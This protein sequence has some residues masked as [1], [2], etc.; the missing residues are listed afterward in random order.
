MV[1]SA[2]NMPTLIPGYQCVSRLGAGGFGEVWRV[3][4]PGG[5]EKAIKLVY[6]LIDEDRAAREL[7]SLDRIKGVRHPFLL[8][9]ERIEIIDGRLMIVT[10][11]AEGSLV[12]RYKECQADG[13][14]GIPREELIGHL[15]DAADALDFMFQRHSLQHLDIK[16]EN[17]LLVGGHTKVADFGLVKEV[18]ERTVS[19][20]GGLTPIYASP[21]TFSGTPSRQSDQYSLAVVYQELLTGKLPFVGNTPAQ[22]AMMH[23]QGCPHLS[24][25]PAA[26]RAIVGRALA[27]DPQ[28]RY[29]SSSDFVNALRGLPAEDSPPASPRTD[30]LAVSGS[31]RN[32][33]DTDETVPETKSAPVP[34]DKYRDDRPNTE[35]LRTEV[36][37]NAEGKGDS[38]PFQRPEDAPRPVI[39]VSQSVRRLKP[40]GPGELPRGLRPTLFVGVGGLGIETVGLLKSRLERWNAAYAAE[41]IRYLV[42]DTDRLAVEAAGRRESDA[43]IASEDRLCLPLRKTNDYKNGPMDCLQWLSRRWLYNIPR[44]LR[45]QGFR[46]LGRLALV[47]HWKRVVEAIDRRIDELQGTRAAELVSE[48]S[49]Q[50]AGE[51]T[52]RV[53]VVGS[54]SGGTGGGML[55]DVGAVTRRLLRRAGIQ[56]PEVH[57]M[58]LHLANRQPTQS[59]L[60]AAS[61]YAT[62]CELYHLTRSDD[63]TPA[64][65]GPADAASR[66]GPPFDATEFV[67]LGEESSKEE[68]NAQ[69]GRLA[70]YLVCQSTS[71]LGDANAISDPEADGALNELDVELRSFA[72]Q[73][74]ETANSNLAQRVAEAVLVE[75]AQ[76]WVAHGSEPL[77]DPRPRARAAHANLKPTGHQKLDSNGGPA[78][79]HDKTNHSDWIHERAA[80]K[81]GKLAS[82]RFAKTV[83]RLLCERADEIAQNDRKERGEFDQRAMVMLAAAVKQLEEI[84]LVAES[85][86]PTHSETDAPL[87][88]WTSKLRELVPRLA[89]QVAAAAWEEFLRRYDPHQPQADAG[90]RDAPPDSLIENARGIALHEAITALRELA[91]DGSI[92]ATGR[93]VPSADSLQC[94]LEA[95]APV[96]PGGHCCRD[97]IILPRSCDQSEASA[98]LREALAETAEVFSGSIEDCPF[99][100]RS[101][102]GVSLAET[103]KLLIGDRRDLMEAARRLHARKDVQWTYPPDVKSKEGD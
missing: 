4:A 10:E 32:V 11:L 30:G 81:F 70:D 76:R 88:E 3:S 22:L 42:L 2:A 90:S 62:L 47:D 35:I 16:P 14:P 56:Q 48:V 103:A 95:L 33:E 65:D 97:S 69:L 40:R 38:G 39:Q 19:L 37:D 60:A 100:V 21:E 77:P 15:H 6:G 41:A 73:R 102:A 79:S 28:A 45:T 34:D 96:V 78:A 93:L 80:Y 64:D 27:K 1:L 61:A 59:A 58:L 20:V 18:V 75:V 52:P 49:G 67:N 85:G 25:L 94:E 29:G 9:L 89:G 13:L 63:E 8:S 44:S 101:A 43:A 54:V 72:V 55:L 99:I 71:P 31:V 87:Y 23:T 98:R 26:D 17:L 12:D 7:K 91:S 24:P 50:P 36:L 57:G 5:L 92:D 74:V 68:L 51:T 83:C 53:F 66:V 84:R 82:S 86:A 46:P